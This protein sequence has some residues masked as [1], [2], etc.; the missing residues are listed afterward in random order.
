MERVALIERERSVMRRASFVNQARVHNGYH[1]PRSLPTAISS[2]HNFQTFLNEYP[3]AVVPD[4]R[5]LYG[6]ASDSRVTAAQFQRFCQDIGAP[7]RED[8]R[9]L[10]DLF[11]PNLMEACFA[12]DEIAFDTTEI[13]RDLTRRLGDAAVRPKPEWPK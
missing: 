7:C 8:R 10:D 9:A 13:A 5:M 6:I 3:F 2:R 11:D 1:Y 12:V 4:T